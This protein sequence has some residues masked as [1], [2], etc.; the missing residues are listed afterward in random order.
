MLGAAI[1]AC[2]L[3]LIQHRTACQCASA[4]SASLLPAYIR[5]RHG[6]ITS[7]CFLSFCNYTL[8]LEFA[9]SLD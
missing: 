7:L 2:K 8:R 6:I 3:V 9:Q 4:D 5:Q 1:P